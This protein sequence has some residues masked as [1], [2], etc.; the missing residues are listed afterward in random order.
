MALGGGKKKT[1]VERTK[2]L[3]SDHQRVLLV[4]VD[5]VGS[6]QFQDI[7]VMLRPTKVLMGKNTLIKRAMRE[8]IADGRKDLEALLPFIKR[9]IGL[10]FTKESLSKIK[11]LC[12]SNRVPAAA[13]AGSIAPKDVWLNAGPTGMEPTKTSF[14]QAVGI[15]SKIVKG[16]V[17]LVSDNLLVKKGDKVSAS[18]AVLL[19]ILKIKPFSYGLVASKAFENGAVFDAEVLALSDDDLMTKFRSG[20]SNVAALSLAVGHPTVASVPHSFINAF[21]DVVSLSLAAD[22]TFDRMKNLKDLLDDPSKLAALTAAAAKPA[23]AAAGGGAAKPAVEEKKEEEEE[24]TFAGGGLFG[25]G[26]EEE[27]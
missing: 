8:L 10:V 17:E 20:L 3:F 22:Y 25:G 5:N 27:W 7:R 2:K 16:Q 6:K 13:K 15:S 21:K 19:E 23:A 4:V 11:D 14:L 9:N 12:E 18:V 1:Y 24:T 26:E